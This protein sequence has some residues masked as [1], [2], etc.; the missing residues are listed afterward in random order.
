VNTENIIKHLHVLWRTDGIIADI[1]L[2]T[3]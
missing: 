2:H 3:F 1:K